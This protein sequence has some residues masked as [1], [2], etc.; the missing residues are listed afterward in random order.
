MLVPIRAAK[1]HAI[2]FRV[3]F[4]LPVPEHRQTRQCAQQNANAKILIPFAK[5]IHRRAL[6][7]V[8]HEIDKAF[9]DFRLEFQSVFDQFAVIGVF[10]VAQHVHKSAVVHTV[11]AQRTDKITFHQ[12]ERFSQQ[13]RVWYLSGDAVNDLTPELDRERLFK[14]LLRKG[15][16][17]AGGDGA[18]GA[19][20]RKP[21]ALEMT[22]GQSHGSVKTDDRKTPGYIQDRLDHLFADFPVEVV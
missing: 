9:E 17:S 2:F 4:D 5:L 8:V 15:M 19:G 11:H 21:E 18:S 20:L 12:P 7:G 14:L 13:Q 6:I 1:L 22:F 10:F 3:S 16:I